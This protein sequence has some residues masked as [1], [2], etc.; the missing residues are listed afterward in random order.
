MPPQ[1]HDATLWSVLCD[2]AGHHLQVSIVNSG[3]TLPQSKFDWNKS[4]AWSNLFSTAI[5]DP[6]IY[7]QSNPHLYVRIFTH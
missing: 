2:L 4:G 1:V 5:G 6:E 7:Q 3:A